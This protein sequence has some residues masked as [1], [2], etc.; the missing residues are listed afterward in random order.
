[1]NPGET[2]L[3]R[4]ALKAVMTN[5]VGKSALPRV[6]GGTP[7]ERSEAALICKGFSLQLPVGGHC[8]EA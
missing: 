8:A 6:V 5:R 3:L 7:V 1:M 4:H 2:R